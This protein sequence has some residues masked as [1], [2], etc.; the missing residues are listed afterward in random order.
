MKY[1]DQTEGELVEKRDKRELKKTYFEI[2]NNVKR[3][4]KEDIAA[5]T[6]NRKQFF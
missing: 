2:I 6:Q 4:I 3:E 1:R 5:T